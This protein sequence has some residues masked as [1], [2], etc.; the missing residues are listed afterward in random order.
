MS[1]RVKRLH[2]SN[3]VRSLAFRSGFNDYYYR[4]AIN[5]D[6]A[7][8]AEVKETAAEMEDFGIKGHEHT[9]TILDTFKKIMRS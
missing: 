1:R 6:A 2:E 8:A 9:A 7:K 5:T 4:A 3:Y